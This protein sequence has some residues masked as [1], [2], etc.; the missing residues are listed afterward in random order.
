MLLKNIETFNVQ[1]GKIKT[2]RDI[3]IFEFKT[4]EKTSAARKSINYENNFV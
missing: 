4:L 1:Y 2:L 3:D